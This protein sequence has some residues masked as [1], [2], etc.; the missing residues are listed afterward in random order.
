MKKISDFKNFYLEDFD[1]KEV[2]VHSLKRACELAVER[3]DVNTLIH[4]GFYNLDCYRKG[5]TVA[6]LYGRCAEIIH[7]IK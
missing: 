1:G 7:N 3:G 5:D 6:T 4:I 2:T